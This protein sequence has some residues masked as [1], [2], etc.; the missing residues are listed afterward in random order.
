MMENSKQRIALL[1]VIFTLLKIGF[2]D[3]PIDKYLGKKY[4][5]STS[6][7]F[8]AVMKAL[9]VS[10]WYRFLARVT[11][12]QMVLSKSG[13][14]YTL[15]LTSLVKN[16]VQKFKPGDTNTIMTPDGRTA[17]STITFDGNV[18]NE[19]ESDLNGKVTKIKRTFN[20]TH[21]VIVLEVDKI[22]AIRTYKANKQ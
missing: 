14:E 19:I 11:T 2:S 5:M 6:E 15:S 20:D 10:M 1:L 16:F 4:T 3:E 9:G 18:L 17:N 21:L 12:P 7:N 13:D 8:D 22:I